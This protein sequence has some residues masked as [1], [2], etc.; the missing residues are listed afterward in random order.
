MM[1]V[2]CRCTPTSDTAPPHT[3]VT[4]STSRTHIAPSTDRHRPSLTAL[5][6]SHTLPCCSLF[7]FHSAAQSERHPWISDHMHLESPLLFQPVVSLVS[8]RASCER[9]PSQQ[10][11]GSEMSRHP[12]AFLLWHP[13]C[14]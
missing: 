13:Q 11:V 7:A 12:H 10:T 8:S 6:V 5:G 3:T 9:H 2:R 4:I 14:Q 1:M